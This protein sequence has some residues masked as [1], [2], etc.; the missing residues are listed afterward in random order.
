MSRVL[1][2]RPQSA[3]VPQEHLRLS[4]DNTLPTEFSVIEAT[5]ENAQSVF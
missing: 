1:Q 5:L 4:E 2:A 3:L